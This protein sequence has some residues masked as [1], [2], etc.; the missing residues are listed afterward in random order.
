MRPRVAAI[1][2]LAGLAGPTVGCGDGQPVAST[3]TEPR[4]G[5]TEVPPAVAGSIR[6][7]DFTNFVYP[8]DSC[9]DV[10][11]ALPI[12]GYDVVEGEASSEDDQH[13][14][15]EPHEPHDPQL[16]DDHGEDFYAVTVREQITYADLTGDGV[17]EALVIM[18]CSPG[19][20][21]FAIASVWT[22]GA[23]GG[24]ERLAMVMENIGT[25]PGRGEHRLESASLGPEGIAATFQVYGEGAAMC[26]PTESATVTLVWRDDAL[27]AAAPAVYVAD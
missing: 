19:T 24:P 26:C 10:F 14:P 25:D 9:R 16:P 13:E 22:M 5:T 15:H 20:H 18:E 27:A 17:D 4:P 1:A 12:E 7:V 6:E 3:G 23:D 8:E 11:H 2:V 21:P